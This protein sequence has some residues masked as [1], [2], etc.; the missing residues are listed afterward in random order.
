MRTHL[1]LLV[2]VVL[3]AA[4]CARGADDELRGLVDDVAPADGEMLECTG[5]RTGAPPRV[6]VE[7]AAFEDDAGIQPGRLCAVTRRFTG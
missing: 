6:L 7:L 3:F 5:A 1:V 4:G 2:A